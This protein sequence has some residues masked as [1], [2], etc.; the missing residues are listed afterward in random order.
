M[1]L[2]LTY[3]AFLTGRPARHRA[4]KP[5][6]LALEIE[7]DVPEAYADAAPVAMALN[8]G[9]SNGAIELRQFEGQ[10]HRSL[11]ITP[12]GL[13][14]Y[15]KSYAF[16]TRNEVFGS[17]AHEAMRHYFTVR[18]D[19]NS[20]VPPRVAMRDNQF[21]IEGDAAAK[22]FRMGREFAVAQKDQD[23]AAELERKAREQ[24]GRLLVI[25]D[26]VWFP[27]CEFVYRATA[28]VGE[29]PGT[30]SVV[31]SA[32][33]YAD[34]YA[35]NVMRHSSWSDPQTR[36]FGALAAEAAAE[37]AGVPLD[38]LPVIEVMETSSVA[39]DF[40]AME[41]KRCGRNVMSEFGS[42]ASTPRIRKLRT[43]LFQALGESNQPDWSPDSLAD[44]LAALSAAVRRF[45]KDALKQFTPDQIDDFVGRWNSRVIDT[46]KIGGPSF[47]L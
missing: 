11:G 7:V 24:L 39:A 43:A 37:Y 34:P 44:V 23:R 20:P 1:L 16:D 25:D 28:P 18:F 10:L 5:C 2:R 46:L 17:L 31:G 15:T 9:Y 45:D 32:S 42:S 8:D 41:L 21:L 14:R 13:A 27:T 35:P 38:G 29:K 6:L 33:H 3:P 40:E 19:H 36:F 30:V 22:I 4:E 12:E 26:T 47:K